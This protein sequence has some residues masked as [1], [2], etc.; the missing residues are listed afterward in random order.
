MVFLIV[1]DANADMSASLA[2]FPHEGDD[3]PLLGLTWQ[4]GGSAANVATALA[5][6]S[7]P[8][9]LVARVGVDPAAEVALR[10]A[11]AAGVDLACVQRDETMATGLCFAAVSPGGE[12]TFF[13]HRGANVA[14]EAPSL[15]GAFHDAGWLHLGGHALIEGRQRETTVALVAEAARRG[16]P[17]SLDLCLPLLRA[18]ANLVTDLSPRLAVLFANEHE[19]A[20]FA[21]APARARPPLVR[22][23]KLGAAGARASGAAG[24]VQAPA[25]AV[26]ATDTTACGDAFVAGFL[27]ATARRAPLEVAVRLGNALGALTATRP[28]AADALPSREE[29]RAFLRERG[30][31]DALAVLEGE[32]S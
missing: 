32:P 9:R 24:T 20:A 7:A 30:A 26:E 28:G 16:V 1:G 4:S 29:A 19:S 27:L 8:A 21:G 6:M 10:A 13:S 17:V 12:R 31:A 2:R 11:R 15:P 25:F 23:E 14:L 3:S 5:R 22:V 18:D